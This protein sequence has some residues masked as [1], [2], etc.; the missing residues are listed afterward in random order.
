MLSEDFSEDNLSKFIYDDIFL[1][2]M[3]SAIIISKQDPAFETFEKAFSDAGLPL[4]ASIYPV[5][6][7]AVFQEDIDRKIDADVFIFASRHSGKGE[8]RS[9]CVHTPG[10]WD[11]A[12]LGGRHGELCTAY[13]SL[14]KL[15]YQQ[16]CKAAQGS[17]Y[18]PTLEVTHHG[19]LIDKPCLFVETGPSEKEWKDQQAADMVAS[20]V[21]EVL[22]KNISRIA[23]SHRIAFGIGGTHYCSNFNKVELDTDIALSHICPK[24]MLEHLDESMVLK[25]FERSFQKPGFA[26]LD[27]K[28]MGKEKQRIISLLESMDIPFMRSDRV[29]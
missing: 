25:A 28:G 17:G 14:V 29:R 18:Q 7:T 26:I 19:P 24:H 16:F 1:H 13:P 10:N 15:V 9:L 5:Q 6:E 21:S 27:W 12:L 8:I 3:K 23:G 22:N 20:S 2:I 4:E 11:K